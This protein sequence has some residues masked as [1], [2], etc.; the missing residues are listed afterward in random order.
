MNKSKA[1]DSGPKLIL[2]IL[3]RVVYGAVL[4]CAGLLMASGVTIFERVG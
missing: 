2:D 4:T 1:L 3:L